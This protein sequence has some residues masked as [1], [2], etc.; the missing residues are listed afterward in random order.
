MAQEIMRRLSLLGITADT[1]HNI[2]E[3]YPTLA[4]GIDGIIARFYAHILSFPEGKSALQNKDIK[5]SLAPRQR[6]HWLK[7][8][9]CSFDDEYYR[10][11]VRIGQVHYDQ[12]ISPYLYLAGYNFF[13]CEMIRLAAQSHRDAV[14]L[15]NL[16]TSISRVVTLDMDLALSAYTREHWMRQTKSP[17][18]GDE[19]S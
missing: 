17:Q 7:L 1:K 11:A 18:P 9:S 3:F 4:G 8:F 5:N 16:L 2:G 14:S 6:T 12:K 15:S 19:T 10:S 13:N